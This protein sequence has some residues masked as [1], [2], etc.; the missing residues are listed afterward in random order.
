MLVVLPV[1]LLL[2]TPSAL[3]DNDFVMCDTADLPE[4][5]PPAAKRRR[6]ETVRL[7]VKASEMEEQIQARRRMGSVDMGVSYSAVVAFH[8]IILDGL[9]AIDYHIPTI[10]LLVHVPSRVVGGGD[11]HIYSYFPLFNFH[12]SDR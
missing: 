8:R 2:F 3:G 10:I 4:T 6:Q 9:V 12:T 7:I 11:D 5:A 1:M